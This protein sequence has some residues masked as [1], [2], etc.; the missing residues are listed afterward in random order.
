[1]AENCGFK[2]VEIGRDEI[3]NRSLPPDRNHNGGFIKEEWITVFRKG[4]E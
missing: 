3:K 4:E 1:M 2:L